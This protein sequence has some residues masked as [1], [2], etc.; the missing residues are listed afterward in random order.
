MNHEAGC[1][2][3]YGDCVFGRMDDAEWGDSIA[4][5]ISVYNEIVCNHGGSFSRSFF[6]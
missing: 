2:N 1:F 3:Y 6:I 4:R 5:L